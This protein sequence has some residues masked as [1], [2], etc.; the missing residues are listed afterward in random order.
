MYFK[1][2]STGQVLVVYPDDYPDCLASSERSELST[3]MQV[4]GW[5]W[6]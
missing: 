3:A 5:P 4:T 1:V 6:T 2:L